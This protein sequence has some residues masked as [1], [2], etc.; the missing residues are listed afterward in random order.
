MTRLTPDFLHHMTYLPE[1]FK[2]FDAN[3]LQVTKGEIIK[4]I[5]STKSK[6]SAGSCGWNIPD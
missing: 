2:I 6:T 3:D 1:Q 5:K 4:A